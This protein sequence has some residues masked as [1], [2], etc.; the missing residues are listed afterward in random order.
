MCGTNAKRFDGRS[1]SRAHRLPSPADRAAA[2][3]LRRRPERMHRGI[4]ALVIGRQQ[5]AAGA[6]RREKCRR[7]RRRDA[8]L[9][10]ER[11]G[12]LVDAEACRSPPDC[13]ARIQNPPVAAE[14]HYRRPPCD[15]DIGLPGQ[16]RRSRRRSRR[17]R[18]C[19]RPAGTR[20]A[21]PASLILSRRPPIGASDGRRCKAKSGT[22]DFTACR[23]IPRVSLPAP[24]A[25]CPD[26]LRSNLIMK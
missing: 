3:R 18:S 21:Y 9:R 10:I 2:R 4:P 16:V 6:V 12:C 13:A 23:S 22:G 8:A 25:T 24:R 11:A 26:Q 20:K 7:V 14:R 5:I 17:M 19:H 15:R 1:R